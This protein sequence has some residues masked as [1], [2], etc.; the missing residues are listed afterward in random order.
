MK[1]NLLSVGIDVGTSTT[2]IIFSRIYIEN[3]S[4]GARVPE[5]KIVDK[6]LFYKGEIHRTPLLSPTVIDQEA[7]T[8]IVENEYKKAGVDPDNVDSGAVIITGETARK[9]NSESIMNALAGYAGEFVVATAGP[10]LEGIIAGRGSGVAKYSDEKNCTVAN[11]D[12][13]GGT[14][15]IGVFKVGEPID[16]ACLDIGGRL[17]HFHDDGTVAYVSD[18]VRD[19]CEAHGISIELGKKYTKKELV[20]VTDLMAQVLLEVIFAIPQTK[21]V[22][23]AVSPKGKKLREGYTID[24]ISFTG[25]VSDYIYFHEEETDDFKYNDIGILLGR[26]IKKAF[27]S[28]EDRIIVPTETIMATVVGAGTQTMDI[29]GS[30]ITYTDEKF[31]IK[32]LPIVAFSKEE[33]MSENLGEIIREKLSW[34]VMEDGLH[35]TALFFPGEA[36]MSYERITALAEKIADAWEDTYKGQEGLIVVLREDMGKVLGQV[37]LRKLE[38]PE[39]SVICLDG[40]KVQNG[41]YI[42]IGNPIGM[43]SVIPVVIKTLVLN[44]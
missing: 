6:E 8:D 39:R 28:E 36:N 40:V 14:T 2:Q 21:D 17:I 5:F 11:F 30:T 22:D 4:S 18:K 12:I 41:D 29:S 44:Y 31:P 38:G 23:I 32:N 33:Q 43:G 25:G 13:G 15:N 1:E 20:N 16:T 35:K 9:E 7:L 27:V 34:Y 24:A 26:S 37:L 42:D 19:L 10:D 3:M